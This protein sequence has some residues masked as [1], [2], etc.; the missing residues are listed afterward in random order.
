MVHEGWLEMQTSAV[1]GG[2]WEKRWVCVSSE[3][4]L[5][6]FADS[7]RTPLEN[8]EIDLPLDWASV[9]IAGEKLLII[10]IDPS[11]SNRLRLKLKASSEVD[12]EYWGEKIKKTM[13][14][15][16]GP[17]LR[18]STM[19]FLQRQGSN[20]GTVRAPPPAAAFGPLARG[21]ADGTGERFTAHPQVC[22][23]TAR[24]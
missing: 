7:E 21:G 1:A 6:F 23:H 9:L 5:L 17:Q 15:N 24:R 4:A 13:E 11:T 8:N 19:D 18:N 20:W 2:F 14:D 16:A 3:P 10:A 12:S 22:R